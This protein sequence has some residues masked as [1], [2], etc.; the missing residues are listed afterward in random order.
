MLSDGPERELQ[1][2]LSANSQ[3]KPEPDRLSRSVRAFLMYRRARLIAR[4]RDDDPL[5][6]LVD[7]SKSES[8]SIITKTYQDTQNKTVDVAGSSRVSL[9]VTQSAFASTSDRSLCFPGACVGL[10]GPHPSDYAHALSAC[11]YFLQAVF[12]PALGLW[13]SLPARR[14]SRDTSNSFL[15][16]SFFFFKY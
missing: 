1:G 13:R 5:L 15:T 7:S 11:Y 16:F 12:L 2:N 6:P 9:S 4:L 8:D 14:V 10:I 3:T